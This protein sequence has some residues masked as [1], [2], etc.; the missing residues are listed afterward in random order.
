MEVL[1]EVLKD[2]ITNWQNNNWKTANK[3]LVKN[4]DLWEE[5]LSLT[6]KHK[7]NFIKVKGHADN[8]FNNRCDE[9]ARNEIKKFANID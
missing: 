1:L 6:K 5:L 3:S 8:E 7:V 9:I 4:V 2:W